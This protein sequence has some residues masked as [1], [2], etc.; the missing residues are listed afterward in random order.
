MK[1]IKIV[2]GCQMPKDGDHVIA[3]ED[4]AGLQDWFECEY[5]KGKF[6]WTGQDAELSSPIRAT[7]WSYVEL[8]EGE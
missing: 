2:E 4:V 7:H 8:P 6:I 1:W 5:L 3:V